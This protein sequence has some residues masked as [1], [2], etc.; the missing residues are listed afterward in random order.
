MKENTFSIMIPVHSKRDKLLI[1]AIKSILNQT[2]QNFECLII[3]NRAIGDIE[4]LVC[5]F[6]DQRLKYF[7]QEGYI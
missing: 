1:R 5:S 3:D 2:Y 4:N 6:K 7:K